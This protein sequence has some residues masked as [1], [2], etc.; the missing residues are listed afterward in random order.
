MNSLKLNPQ[1]EFVIA[2]LTRRIDAYDLARPKIAGRLYTELFGVNGEVVSNQV[3]VCHGLLEETKKTKKSLDYVID[4]FFVNYAQPEEIA[5]ALIIRSPKH[6][7][8]LRDCS[9][10]FRSKPEIRRSGIDVE[11]A[12]RYI[13]EGKV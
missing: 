4:Y 5:Q 6:S 3:A 2:E 10:G 9:L 1:E 13:L 12:T 7:L 8:F 11:Q